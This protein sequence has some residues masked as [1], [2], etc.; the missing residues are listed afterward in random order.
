MLLFVGL[1]VFGGF[2]HNLNAQT[3]INV[4]LTTCGGSFLT[5]DQLMD[6]GGVPDGHRSGGTW[7][8]DDGLTFSDYGANPL[9]TGFDESVGSYSILW[10][11]TPSKIYSF[12]ISVPSTAVSYSLL[13]ESGNSSDVISSGA[14][15]DFEVT[16][17]NGSS[18]VFYET[19][20]PDGTPSVVQSGSSSTF[21]YNV[22]AT[23]VYQIHAVIT[24]PGGCVV[25]TDPI[26]ISQGT[27]Q[28]RVEGGQ[29]ICD[30]TY[31]YNLFVR[32]Y[33][34][35]LN[36]AW[37]YD[38]GSGWTV[39][40]PSSPYD[41]TTVTGPGD[42]RAFVYTG[43]YGNR[44]HT[45]EIVTVQNYSLPEVTIDPSGFAALCDATAGV[46]L[47][48]RMAT[49]H[50]EPVTYEWTRNDIP[51]STGDLNASPYTNS[52]TVYS[53]ASYDFRVYETN[54]PLCYRS[55][56][57]DVT[58]VTPM[59]TMEAENMGGCGPVEP[60]F[61]VEIIGQPGDSWDVTISDGS[62]GTATAS[63]NDPDNDGA[64]SASIPWGA[65]IN[66][67]TT[68]SLNAVSTSACNITDFSNPVLFEINNY[69]LIYDVSGIGCAGTNI[70][71]DL[72]D[73]EGDVDYELYGPSG[74]VIAT[75]NGTGNPISFNVS[76]AA[77]GDYEIRGVR[78]TCTE[79][80]NGTITVANTPVDKTVNLIGSQCS[81][82]THTIRVLASED[83]VYYSL[84]LDDGTLVQSP[85][86]IAGGGDLDF[87]GVD[88]AGTY[89]V[90]AERGSC[91]RIVG[92]PVRIFKT[93][94][95]QNIVDTE[96]CEGTPLTVALDG[97]ENNFDYRLFDNINGT[98]TNI[99]TRTGDGNPIT[100]S[101]SISAGGT[102]SIIASNPLSPGGA[103]TT[104]LG[105]IVIY[106]TPDLTY[107]LSTTTVGPVCEGGSHTIQLSDSEVGVLYR[108][109]RDDFTG[110]PVTSVWGDGNDVNFPVPQSVAGTYLVAAVNNNCEYPLSGQQ[111]VISE[112]PDAFNVTGGPFCVGENVTIDVSN[113]ETGV[114]YL[115]YRDGTPYAGSELSGTT[116][117]PIQFSA[118]YPEGNYTVVAE[119][120]GCMTPMNGSVD[121]NPIPVVSIA[122][123]PDHYCSGAG[124]QTIYGNPP[125]ANA[126][127]SWNVQGMGNPPWFTNHDGNSATFNVDDALVSVN[128]SQ[129]FTFVYTYTNPITGCSN[130]ASESTTFHE[131]LT[132][133][134]DFRYQDATGWHTFPATG[135]LILC[136]DD[137][138]INLEGFF[139]DT[140][141][142]I[143]GGDFSGNGVDDATADD[144]LA[145]FDPAVA[146]NGTHTI[147]FDY[148]DI[149]GCSGSV[150]YNIQI[151][152]NLQFSS[153]LVDTYCI[154][155]NST[156]T[157]YGEPVD[158]T[159]P[160]GGT[161]NLYR[162]TLPLD[163]TETAISTVT[164]TTANP[165]MDFVPSNLGATDENYVFEYSYDYNGCE[166][167]ITHE[168]LIPAELDASF[169]SPQT[170][171]CINDSP[172]LFTPTQPG[173]NYS[174]NGVSG[175]SF[176]PSL[177]GQG[178]HDITYSI[179]TGGCYSESTISLTV[180]DPPIAIVLADNEFCQNDATLYP[181]QTN[182]LV[183]SSGVYDADAGFE[184][185]E[186]TFSAPNECLFTVDG[187]GN[188]TYFQTNTTPVGD[189]DA[190]IYFDP[191]LA[192]VGTFDITLVFDNTA[193]G[194]CEKTETFEVTVI[195]T[196]SVN[197]G[198]TDPLEF[199]QNSSPVIFEGRY[200]GGGATGLGY[201]MLGSP[202][203]PT[204]PGIDNEVDGA[205]TD[206]NGRAEF[207]PSLVAASSAE[208]ITYV[209]EQNGCTSTRTKEFNIRSAPTVFDVTPATPNG[210][211]YCFGSDATIGLSSS[212]E[213]VFYELLRDGTV[214]DDYTGLASETS[215][216]FPAV[217]EEGTY[218]VRA[219]LPATADACTSMMNGSV[220]VRE[221][222]VT[223]VVDY[224]INP[225][226]NGALDGEIHVSASSLSSD[227]TYTLAEDDGTGTFT[228]IAT[229]NTGEFT[230]LGGGIYEITIVDGYG[231]PLAEALSTVTLTEPNAIALTPSNVN[232]VT[233]YGWNDGSF[234]IAATGGKS[235]SY[236]FSLNG[237]PWVTN[238]SSQYTFTN[239]YAGTYDVQVRDA[240]NPS[241]VQTLAAGNEVDIDEPNG[242][243]TI[244]S[245]SSVTNVDC[246]T[247]GEIQVEGDQ[248]GYSGAFNYVLY[249]EASPGNWVQV[250]DDNQPDGTPAVFPITIGGDYR[251][252]IF[253]ENNC[254][255]SG[256]YNVKAPASKPVVNL[257][258]ITN[259][260][261][262]GAGDG[263]IEI[264][265]T[266]GVAPFIIDWTGTGVT[267]GVTLQSNLSAGTYSVRVT[268]ANGCFDELLNLDV[269]DND[270][271]GLTVLSKNPGPCF[272]NNNGEI[273]LTAT[274]GVL[275]Y[276]PITL[277]NSSGD[278]I[279]PSS[280]GDTYA[281]YTGLVAGNYTATVVDGQPLSY[282]ENITLSQDP[283]LILSFTKNSDAECFG[284]NGEITFSAT[285][286]TGVG[287]YEFTVIPQ[288]GTPDT[289]AA[290]QSNLP[291]S[292]DTYELQVRDAN[293]CYDNHFFEITE[294]NELTVNVED[295][296]HVKCNAG[297]DGEIT[298][299]VNGRPGGTTFDYVWE[300]NDGVSGWN[301]HSS[302]TGTSSNT[303]TSLFAG[304]YRVSVRESGTTCPLSVS[305]NIGVDEPMQLDLQVENT[306]HV[307]TCNGESTGSVRLSVTGGTGLY[308]INYGTVSDS[309]DG[310][311]DYTVT[312]LSAGSYTFEVVDDNGCSSTESVTITEPDPFS[313]SVTDYGI[314]CEDL[315]SGYVNFD[316][317]GGLDDGA[318]NYTYHVR[319]VRQEN[320]Q[321]YISNDVTVAAQPETISSDALIAGAD[322]LIEGTYTL[323]VYDANSSDPSNCMFETQFSLENITI[324]DTL[325]HPTCSGLDNG[326]IDITVSGGSGVYNYTWYDGSIAPGNELS[327]ITNEII[328]LSPGTYF[329][330]V[331]DDNEGCVITRDY[332]IAYTNTLAVAVSKT[333][334]SCFNSTDGS[335]TATAS[336]GVAPYDYIW[337]KYNTTTS[338]WETLMN[339]QTLDPVGIG[340]YRV[341]VTDANGCTI[342]ADPS[343]TVT[344]GRPDD[345]TIDSHAV[346]NHVSCN[347]GS[348]ASF[349]II[350]DPDP[351]VSGRNFE[352]SID[353][354]TTWQIN[355]TFSGLSAGG[356]Q[357]SMRERDSAQ[358][359]CTKYDI[360]SVVITEPS[361]LVVDLV[362]I[363]PVDCKGNS[364]GSIEV[365]VPSGSGTSPYTYQWYRVTGSGNISISPSL[366]ATP[367]LAEGLSAGD[368]RVRVT[369]D[370]GCVVW[371]MIYEVTEPLTSP[372]ITVESVINVSA[373]AGNDGSIEVSV[374]GGTGVYSFDWE[375]VDGTGALIDDLSTH[376][377]DNSNVIDGLSAGNYR[378]NVLDGNSCPVSQIVTITEPGALLQLNAS[379]VSPQPCNDAVNGEIQLVATGGQAPY[380]FTLTR[381]PG[382]AI[383]ASSI[384]G[385]FAYYDNL[386][387]GY[388]NAQVEDD[389]GVV[390]TITNIHLTVPDPVALTVTK[391]NDAT[392]Y[393]NSDG[394]ITIQVTGGTPF[395]GDPLDA[396]IPD[397]DYY[398]YTITPQ[399]GSAIN[400]FVED[401]G[402]G[403]FVLVNNTLPAD[404]Y[405]IVVADANYCSDLDAFTINQPNEL[406]IDLTGKQDVTCFDG[407]DGSLS[408]KINGRPAGTSFTYIWEIDADKNG[409]WAAYP[410]TTGTLTN[411]ESG[412]YRV[413]A[414]EALTNCPVPPLTIEIDEPAEVVLTQVA[415]NNVTTC[416]GDNSGSVRFSVVGGTA[417]YTIKYGTVETSWDGTGDFTATGLTAGF[418][419]FEV[420]DANGCSD[421]IPNVEITEPAPLQ[422]T[423]FD[424]G[425][426]CDQLTS[427][428]L[429]FD[430]AGGV[431]DGGFRYDVRLIRQENNQEYYNNI[432]TTSP[433]NITNLIE[434]TYTLEV[435]DANSTASDGCLFTYDFSLEN[436]S[437]DA[438]VIQPTCSGQDNGSIDITVTG[439]SGSYT[440]NWS[441][442][443]GSFTSTD[444]DISNLAPET[445]TLV[446][447]DAVHGCS[448]LP[449]PEFDLNYTN[450]LSV[451]AS[452]SD[453]S[454][455]N[456]ADGS[457]TATATGGLAPYDYIWEKYNSTSGLWEPLANRQTIDPAG[458]GIYMVTVV[459]A[460]GCEV[461]TENDPTS[462][463]VLTVG[464]PDDFSFSI[465]DP[466]ADITNV[467]CNGGNDG[468]FE[469]T[470]SR[471]DNFEYSIDGGATW[472]ISPVFDNLAAGVY[473]VSMRDLDTSAPY[474]TKLDI[475]NVEITQPDPMV[476][477]LD[478]LEDVDCHGTA[479]GSLI[480]VSVGGGT[481]NMTSGTPVYTYQWYRVESG[482]NDILVG[483]NTNV[484]AD[485]PAGDYRVRI[486][487]DNICD[488]WS[489]IYTISEPAT[490]P[491]I[492]IENEVHPSAPGASDGT[493]TISIS[494]GTSPYSIAWENA[495]GVSYGTDASISGL[496]QDSYT[497]TV[498]DANNCQVDET[499]TLA[500]PGTALNLT[501]EEQTPPGPCNGAGN[502]VIEL[503]ATGGN[504]ANYTFSLVRQPSTTITNGS[505]SGNI[506]RY[507]NLVSGF[508]TARVEDANGVVESI[509]GIDL[510]GPDPLVLTVNEVRDA[511]CP[512]AANGF[513]SFD[514]SGGDISLGDYAYSIIPQSGSIITGTTNGPGSNN[515][516]SAGDYLLQ[517]TDGTGV[518]TISESFTIG[519]P[520]PIVIS[521]TVSQISCNGADD[522]EIFFN[523]SGG[524][525]PYT[526]YT[527]E[528]F[529]AGSPA[530][531]IATISDGSTSIDGL[532]PG[533]YYVVATEIA[534]T[535]CSKQSETFLIEEPD[536][537][538]V[539][540]T[541][542]D[543]TTCN[544][545]NS[546]SI[547]VNVTGGT[548]PYIVDYGVGTVSGGGPIFTINDLAANTYTITVYDDHNC[549]APAVTAVINEP[550]APL[551]INNIT[552]D[553]ACDGSIAGNET[554]G[555]VS[556]DISGGVPDGAGDFSYHVRLLNTNTSVIQT[557]TVDGTSTVNFTGLIAGNYEIRVRDN[558]ADASTGCD[559]PIFE[560]F[561]LEHIEISGNEVNATCSGIQ[562]GEII[563]VQV[564]GASS[565]YTYA[566]TPA[567]AVG[568]DQNSLDQ[569]GLAPGTYTL[570]VTD[571]GSCTISKDFTVENDN[572]LNISASVR[573]I[574]CAGGTDGAIRNVQ[575]TGA[576]DPS[577]PLKYVW[578]GPG[579]GTITMMS[580]E[581]G[582]DPNLYDLEPGSYTLSVTD[583]NS[584]DVTKVFIIDE[585][586][587]ITF[588]LTTSL[589]NCSPYN[590]SI[591]INN[592]D[593]SDG[594]GDPANFT[595]VWNGPGSF[596]IAG[597]EQS[598]S[599]IKKA[600]TYTVRI[601]DEA[602]CSQEE[603]ITVFGDISVEEDLT[604]VR[605]NGGTDGSIVLTITGGSGNYT[606]SWVDAGGNPT[607][608][609]NVKNQ[610]GLT[611][612]TYTVTISDNHA[613]QD[614]GG[615]TNPYSVTK[616][617]TITQP[618]AIDVDYEKI[619]VSCN[620]NADGQITMDVTGGSGS[621]EYAWT[622]ASALGIV[623]GLR[624]QVGL[625]GGI[626]GVT[627]TD[628]LTGCEQNTTIEII[629][630][631]VLD[632]N[633]TSTDTQCNGTNSITLDET[634]ATGGFGPYEFSAT[635]PGVPSGWTESDDFVDVQGGEY[636]FTLT[637]LGSPG[638][639]SVTKTVVLAKP[640]SITPVV[641]AETC[642]DS[643]NGA[644][645][646][647]VEG[648]R[649]P[650]TFSWIDENGDPTVSPNNKNQAG[651]SGGQYTVTYSD[652]RTCG[653]TLTVE[654]PITN[655]I[656]LNPSITPIV[657][658]G[659]E[660]GAISINPTGGS[661]NYSFAWRGP[662]G[663]SST[664]E[665]I[666][667]L[668]GGTYEVEVVDL[669][670][671]H[672]GATC[673][674]T[675]SF[676]VSQPTG[677]I[678]VT[679]VVTTDV[680]CYGSATGSIEVTVA[681]GMGFYTYAWSGPGDLSSQTTNQLTNV[682]AG[683]YNLKVT[684]AVTGC[685]ANFGPYTIRQPAQPLNIELD[686]VLHVT[687]PSGSNGAIQVNVTGG[688]G[689]Y[690]YDW[691]ESTGTVT[692]FDDSNRN[693][694]LPAGTYTIEVED[695]NGCTDDITVEVT[696]P[697]SALAI[698]ET[699]KDVR[700]CFGNNNGEIR[701]QASG[702]TPDMASGSATY[703]I[704]VTRG[705][706]EIYN[707]DD[708]FI[709]R[710]NLIP[711]SYHIEVT[712]ANGVT[713]TTDVTI[714]EPPVINIAVDDITP[715]TCV[716]GNDGSIEVTVSGGTP[717]DNAGTFEYQMELI[718]PAGTS[719]KITTTGNHTFNTLIA[720]NYTL[721]VWDDSNEDGIYSN[722]TAEDDCYQTISMT[723]PQPHVVASIEV[724]PGYETLC[725]GES[726]ELLLTIAN[727]DFTSQPDLDITLNDG[728][729]V[730]VPESP[731]QFT[732]TTAPSAG[733]VGYE[734]T[735]VVET[736]TTC[737][738]GVGN[739]VATVTIHETPT[740][741]IYGDGRLCPGESRNIGVSL[742]GAAP[743]TIVYT[744]GTNNYTETGITSSTKVI[745]VSPVETTTYTLVSVTDSHCTGTVSGDATV[746]VDPTTTVELIAP[747][748]PEICRGDASYIDIDFDP[749]SSGPW[750]VTYQE[751]DLS[752]TPVNHT[753]TVESSD[754]T[755]V[756]GN[757]YYRLNVS[758]LVTTEYSLVSVT[759][760][761]SGANSCPATLTG[762]PV[763]IT[764][765]EV[766]EAAGDIAGPSEVCQVDT[767]TYSVP[768]ITDADSYTWKV[769]ASVGSIIS[770]AGT[771]EIQVEFDASS[772]SGYI[773]VQGT[774]GCGN[775]PLNRLY[776]NVR[777]APTVGAITGPSDLCQS[778]KG[779]RYSVTPIDVVEG[780]QWTV[781]EGL[782]IV[783]GQNSA[784]IIVDVDDATTATAGQITATPFNSCGMSTNVAT[785]AVTVNANPDA[786][787]GSDRMICGP[788]IAGPG[789]DGNT[790]GGT[791]TGKWT[792]VSGY[793]NINNVNAANTTLTNISSGDLVLE[794]KVTDNGTQC[795]STDQVVIRNNKLNVEADVDKSLTC[796]GSTDI[797]GTV[798]PD[799]TSG[800]WSIEPGDGSGIF[801]DA[802]EAGTTVY[803]LAP[804]ENTLRW[805][806]TQNGCES[807]A[808]V[809]VVNDQAHQAEIDGDEIRQL[810]GDE[811]SLTAND[812]AL[813]TYQTGK[814]TVIK[815][816]ANFDDATSHNVSVTNLSMGENVLRWTITKNG[817]CTTFDE[818][819]IY[820]NQLEV[821]AGD[822]FTT[823]SNS[824]VL[825]G[826]VPPAGAS[827]QWTAVGAADGN[828]I[829]ADGNAWNTQVDNLVNGNNTFR[830]TI[831]LNGCDT[832]DEV[833]IESYAAT[834]ADVGT[835]QT[836]CG[837]T[838]TLTG[839]QE[840]SYESGRWSIVK[841][842]GSFDDPTFYNTDV[843]GV[844][845][846]ENIYRWTIK[847][848]NCSSSAE[849]TVIN[850]Q[851]EAFAGKDTVTCEQTIN[852]AAIPAP[853]GYV[854]YWSV[855]PGMGSVT[856]EDPNTHANA[857]VKLGYGTNQLRWTVEHIGSGCTS[858]DLVT[859]QVNAI[860]VVEAGGDQTLEGGDGSTN[861]QATKAPDGGDG[862]WTIISGGGNIDDPTSPTTEVTELEMG[863]NVFMWTVTLGDCSRS[864]QVTIT[865]GDVIQAETIPDFIT[866]VS[867]VQ[868]GA[869]DPG[870]A[871]GRWTRG[872]YG[873]GEIVDDDNPNTMVRNLGPGDNEFVWTISYGPG[874]TSTS[875]VIVVTNNKPDEAR[876]KD[877]GVTCDDTFLLEGNEPDPG[878]GTVSWS[879]V[880]GGGD[881][882]DPTAV[883]TEVTNLMQGENRFVYS[884]KKG[885]DKVCYSTD[886]ITVINGTPTT[887]YAGDDKTLCTD[888]VLLEPNVP[889][890]G[891]GEWR[892]LEGGAEFDGNMARRITPGVNRFLWVI[893]TDNCSLQDTVTITNNEP[894]VANAG[895]DRPVC[896]NT[897]VLSGSLPTRHTG[898]WTR[899]SGSGEIQNPTEPDAEVTN[900]GQ[901]ENKFRWTITNGQCSDWDDV[902]IRNDF[903]EAKILYLNPE[904]ICVDT[905][906]LRANNPAP[907]VGTWGVIGGSGSASF[908]N[909]SN[910]NTTVRDL[911][912]G[913][914]I[915]TWTVTN[916][917]CTDV[918]TVT[919]VNN[920]PTEADAGGNF[921]SCENSVTLSANT[922][923]VGNGTWTVRNGSGDF[924]DANNP[925]T[926]VN[927]LNFG[928]NVFRW[929]IVNEGCSS[930][931]DVQ[932]DYNTIEPE[933]GDDR[934][935][936]SD[937]EVLQAAN[938]SPGTGTWTVAGGT[939]QATFDNINDPGT[940]VRNLRKGVNRLKWTV[941][942]KGCQTT[943]EVSITN[944]SPSTA[945]AGNTQRK[946]ADATV[947]DALQPEIGTGRW[948]IISGSATISDAD[949]NNPKASVTNI[950]KGE[951]V[952]R[953][954][955]ENDICRSEDDVLIVNNLP[956]TPFA[957]SDLT[958]CEPN[959]DLMAS[960]PEYG[961]GFWSIV[962]GGGN[963]SDV[964]DPRAKINNLAQGRN[965]LKWTV[966]QGQCTLSDEIEITNN[967]ATNANAGPDVADC[968]D[969]SQLDA[970]PP[971]QGVGEWYIV[972]GNGVF[973]NTADESTVIR[974]LGFGENILMWEIWNG[975]GEDQCFSRDTVVIFNKVP[976]QSDAGN[977]KEFCDNYTTLNANL[978]PDGAI[979]TWTVVSGAG[980]FESPNSNNSIVRNIGFGN[981]V[982]KWTISYDDCVTESTVTI[983]SNKTDAYAGEDVVVY[984]PEAMLNANN[985]G[986]LNARWNIVGGTGEFED[987][988]FF[989][990][991]VTGLSEGINTYR[992][993]IDVEGCTSYDD[994]S[995]EYRPVPDAGFIT[996][997]D[998]GCW[999]LEVLFTNYSVGVQNRDYHW[1000]FGDGNSSGDQ[1001]PLHTFEDPGNY[1002]VTLTVPGPDG[1003][1004]GRYQ[1005]IIRVY[1006]HPQAA[1007]SVMPEVVY[1008]PGDEVRFF[1009]LSVDAADYLWDF[1010]DG[1011]SSTEAHPVHEYTEGGLYDV[1012]LHVTNEFGCE[1013]STVIEGAVTAISK[1014]FIKFPNAFRP[1015]PDG[1016]SS[1017]Q[1018]SETNILF[1019][1020]VYR[1021]VDTYQ[1022]QIYNRWGQLI[1023]E[1024]TD[1025]DEGWNGLYKGQLA[1026]QAVY[1027]WRVSG[1028]FVNGEEFRE[1029]GSVL[1030][1031]R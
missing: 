788:E 639:C 947:L 561:T 496:V 825:N 297:N 348:D 398:S 86:T 35:D 741:T 525:G 456:A 247:P 571:P 542:Q 157:I 457:V 860:E 152:T 666:E 543:I 401:D 985:V 442:G 249:R 141:V 729:E 300:Y 686:E 313:V 129:L 629:E 460:N 736:G 470:P 844:G 101:S 178:V 664:D 599:N 868:L 187:A 603:S 910:P 51:Y 191:T 304:T 156:Y 238:G 954:I 589:D 123:F 18:I 34:P 142:A 362:N 717:L 124:D 579:I 240:G 110:S 127:N 396:S 702:G 929:T 522:G 20:M 511:E 299:S 145:I 441:D 661:G 737:S 44:Q 389:N 1027:V 311:N 167:I 103:C 645:E 587:P 780:F 1021:D 794:W 462:V 923:V 48:G 216:T 714:A 194:Q 658:F 111:V 586:N 874:T 518:C 810:C 202:G 198:T 619:D 2:V 385:G 467:T 738:K 643:N 884:I 877:G 288:T 168:I 863:P 961:E 640:I 212:E 769:P 1001:N 546:G 121:V 945:Y 1016:G 710:K 117:S 628:A 128:G 413:T 354:G 214:V 771:R 834:P 915:L 595:Y 793:A 53:T 1002:S 973:D 84:Y 159:L 285:G 150:S 556:F 403:N 882:A 73:S 422:V 503:R 695:D 689:S 544:G 1003:I 106:E 674:F 920:M 320:N 888:S 163:G 295:I 790:P 81:G 829:F 69:P 900:L 190:P 567:A 260:S 987:P 359:Y 273:S 509:T 514:I 609:P 90:L 648:G 426:L 960:T 437:I 144:G 654:V 257:E 372:T 528:W 193:A 655:D 821:D 233:C 744:D 813:G 554:S 950:A 487:D 907:G 241:C 225:T 806:I 826:T 515:T 242:P 779:V 687:V 934:T 949:I 291:L 552:S 271:L 833:T 766:P 112:T 995:V 334:V 469:V 361:A 983:K 162:T 305:G 102:Y 742:T 164:S 459:D 993:V 325:V 78:G 696:E 400:G 585:P 47:E 485:R 8:D 980:D 785:Y 1029:T 541:P 970:N 756:A 118:A 99:Q 917:H 1009:D 764:V 61:L 862:Y 76:A 87:S 635:G 537:L 352:Y 977:D 752:G 817:N 38:D 965:V 523:I 761:Y 837:T 610:N 471:A 725:R 815:G 685:V 22:P 994:V 243:V 412:Y 798:L 174:G 617:Y 883:I 447:T 351:V 604:H 472:Q 449:E 390:E 425:I 502:G 1025:I 327:S 481:P 1012:M 6:A 588:D 760:T 819:R 632:F 899:I 63:L 222:K 601:I 602:G 895:D 1026:P 549:E 513:I 633:V 64:T 259:E 256:Y 975:S 657:C 903:K 679:D 192:P 694:G 143:G 115:L 550:A 828:A 612:G 79:W 272:G 820:N 936:C 30:G 608:N 196:P 175:D 989:N 387:P 697:G 338:A 179:N 991:M 849:L 623:P 753:I 827:G 446:L 45:S 254:S 58:V 1006:D 704:V 869:N 77:A 673:T 109:Y 363:V 75:Q 251:V 431:D 624:K 139:I 1019:R 12:N 607:A 1:F 797:Y 896:E 293:G 454:C 803:D 621:Y 461:A 56:T 943:K 371:S 757:F 606:Y 370:N 774:N 955:V 381:Q 32:P 420:F 74:T 203:N 670:L 773:T 204:A 800:N 227:F 138:S 974:D 931:D 279:T 775:G 146:G 999:P 566:W 245:S 799:N 375:E 967:T 996:D 627:V 211:I 337:E 274:G 378:V 10:Q 879:I 230:G 681:G 428:W 930:I 186:Y 464:Q 573:D 526:S 59:A 728:S 519:E 902:I 114:S 292:A 318:G 656:E 668:A 307:T 768:V 180:Y 379:S 224:T 990:T 1030:L 684:D 220:E 786:D 885:V 435:F 498:T 350:P 289:Y 98:G 559:N 3:Y 792:I 787:A 911:A 524:H 854:G 360:E 315:T 548:P 723:V 235:G 667:N 839:N 962:E 444:E 894:S 418:Y 724:V 443:S 369:D 15:Q 565:N 373:A 19:V 427:G 939:S 504:D 904:P 458:L 24:D 866:C 239:L 490:A 344:V 133:N 382:T 228:D 809:V 140:G 963:I 287:S 918:A 637:D 153:N 316:V 407:N 475:D 1028:T 21:S 397:V 551:S 940:T 349:T 856:W 346:N 765:N 255:T 727:W 538:S 405:E 517:V 269:D 52:S 767:A 383:A 618:A 916:G 880:S 942:Y 430:V 614:C 199:C 189:G 171:F 154:S 172:V 937:T 1031:V 160:D 80:M 85:R 539:T 386:E 570:T 731:F 280:S 864:D 663:F 368:Y 951:N 933:V 92:S 408:V 68:F 50:S 776:V 62:G 329:V 652:D 72:S 452:A 262:P 165:E 699:H 881:I 336:G 861:L 620:G 263:S 322:K 374:T 547:E 210:G 770:G 575:V 278:V 1005:K 468:R 662:D 340:D 677:P 306:T 755:T 796:D 39:I 57:E 376:P 176:D 642:P 367:Y 366:P 747:T 155:D 886:T 333:D 506:A 486:F 580:D 957:G 473:A 395:A 1013:D 136:Q 432:E 732:P 712:D 364:T 838:T 335:V 530:T 743:W 205:G 353:G 54:N 282:S 170:E 981:N 402:T 739:G 331:E 438:T 343:T 804:G 626:Y 482:V 706:D 229:S 925:N 593:S 946:C 969:W 659:E 564:T 653:G 296:Q 60:S 421:D 688:T 66:T 415:K 516:L 622:P 926:Q 997:V 433:V 512:G 505:I 97:S 1004:E 581:F 501:I 326:S 952:F 158:G 855:E 147:T 650:F 777:P 182:N 749:A 455:Y 576:S 70:Q 188:R 908:D 964:T 988:A 630:P 719:G 802:T 763:T 268:D 533:S 477:A 270:A 783:S 795:Y 870:N 365:E 96:G 298:V 500:D 453:A 483:E 938:P 392:C 638:N 161:I 924:V 1022:I 671:Q 499:I 534:P 651:L 209:Y 772:A 465:V 956:S 592:L 451:D 634:S 897:V 932:V 231:C 818:I 417:P 88:I 591:T 134:I 705:A 713:E 213:D 805:T 872:S 574:S 758:P 253:G 439:G 149:N 41:A 197:F 1020:P 324:E 982:Y 497:V 284:G 491:A 891:T 841:G 746:T 219:E 416:N 535:G 572:V 641:T 391:D 984:E 720:G 173:G 890:H 423:N 563:N 928:A 236:E 399:N 692:S 858:S 691:T 82:D 328:D 108:L 848:Q 536:P 508:Y 36:Y 843:T 95:M 840:E 966:S 748:V 301:L 9:I 927:G 7:I 281:N 676:V 261:T 5:G 37:E 131:D 814:W 94:D 332:T 221:N 852:L 429:I 709:E 308:I 494:G 411:L 100:F 850:N 887:P 177:A 105:D 135:N 851:V 302:V 116:G 611:A 493:I 707:G 507:E 733:V 27:L 440:Y 953:W 875:D 43:N 226:C 919:I 845:Y 909:P 646:L 958:V 120:N 823:C 65:V 948:E 832:P 711:G 488:L 232:D 290:G 409:T 312:G 264:G 754:L 811:I 555:T 217:T 801:V 718:G 195:E 675:E 489:D 789:L 892:I 119:L 480:E 40:A 93:P 185:A 419:D 636:N 857:R 898:E 683:A 596:A 660:T 275:P 913:E 151:G 341:T 971:L 616:N 921:A 613:D 644:I 223:A 669:E 778:A 89:E 355:E 479:T 286:G 1008:V 701:I 317:S 184:S 540:A 200:A 1011:N 853:A 201:F 726:P 126:D 935:V 29:S 968:K 816:R 132:D 234:R 310:L 23:G 323:Q 410:A 978:P 568:I 992:W 871:I 716:G 345:F 562:D 876:P 631:A 258:A 846:G 944:A 672:Y 558:N 986:D 26:E 130:S 976:E 867:D 959:H 309:W 762:L 578:Q 690:S 83:G 529:D 708:D 25:M 822:G 560:T 49:S 700:P 598:I 339:S 404:D 545:D 836:I 740:A 183:L 294:P 248:A 527:Y 436:I 358:P 784:S 67:S 693:E 414:E 878:M 721:R 912:Q 649:S 703:H 597:D 137:A 941:S 434:G 122:P 244:A 104:D 91:S 998:E 831:S 824:V 807:F 722:G 207:D 625:E 553:I 206:N 751:D 445:Y 906:A 406:T 830:W 181:L 16:P 218:T 31:G 46:T 859:I 424:Y 521:G 342:A 730:T 267:D 835:T 914:N 450:T 1007:F 276:A 510:T 107:T 735:S 678:E 594:T 873:S 582:F 303:I 600:G 590:R 42:Y 71:I 842:S 463:D 380:T 478:N 113:S 1017:H 557:Q 750:E 781:P 208:Q 448:V 314:E 215:F 901:G 384:S 734:V 4:S 577:Q 283:E 569:S 1018:S 905:V 466:V 492:T 55:A 847:N 11:R 169:T 17:T 759:D 277:T 1000:D 357:V 252:D 125:G 319:V 330:E 356:Y 1014:G 347:G 782:T 680:K 166:N 605:C 532:A 246:T 531:P 808:E 1023:Y 979:G 791:E 647:E 584:C 698:S 665:D 972:S 893:S 484:L 265:I 13:N 148:T 922:P 33:D 321:V 615:G 865:N 745:E 682:G 715:V 474:C 28:L 583:G 14:I 250:D 495:A 812:P 476:I 237:T 889:N 1015:R 388:Y 266:G 394:Q 520:D 377:D 393:G 1010:G 1024:S